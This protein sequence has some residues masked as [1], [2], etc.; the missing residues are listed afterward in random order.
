MRL[1]GTASV[2]STPASSHEIR[3]TQPSGRALAA[4]GPPLRCQYQ[5]TVMNRLDSVSR[6]RVGIAVSCPAPDAPASARSDPAPA[7]VRALPLLGQPFGHQR[8]TQA[9]AAARDDPQ[10]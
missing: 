8:R 6:I 9:L 1:A 4:S 5:A 3:I 7:P 2:Y 10:Q